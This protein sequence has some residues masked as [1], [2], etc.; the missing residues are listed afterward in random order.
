MCVKEN[1]VSAHGQVKQC[2]TL[3]ELLVVIAI[4]AILAGMLLPALN[5]AREK[6]RAIS[7]LNNFATVGKGLMMYLDDNASFYPTYYNHEGNYRTTSKGVFQLGSVNLFAPYVAAAAKGNLGMIGTDLKRH[8][9][10]CPSRQGVQ[11]LNIFTMSINSHSFASS[12]A[13]NF[14]KTSI[15]FTKQPSISVYFTESEDSTASNTNGKVALWGGNTSRITYPHSKRVNI[16]FCDGHVGTLG[17]SQVS[18][19]STYWLTVA[20]TRF[21]WHAATKANDTETN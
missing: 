9:M 19:S 4:I 3:I 15:K 8:S 2:F 14:R 21:W 11:G 12:D 7:C 13:T 17:R 5:Q 18:N 20:N 10:A 16:L 1:K 6:G